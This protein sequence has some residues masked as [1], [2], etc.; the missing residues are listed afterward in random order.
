MHVRLSERRPAQNSAQ[1]D[2]MGFPVGH[3]QHVTVPGEGQVGRDI[4]QGPDHCLP[5]R[6][7]IPQTDGLVLGACGER[8]ARWRE[9]QAMHGPCVPNQRAAGA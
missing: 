4:V 8:P 6:R 7:Y 9:G 5:G 1:V 3:S 2:A